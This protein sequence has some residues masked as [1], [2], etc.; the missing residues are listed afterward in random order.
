MPGAPAAGRPGGWAT[1][2]SVPV[3]SRGGRHLNALSVRG[4]PMEC[5]CVAA[6]FGSPFLGLLPS[7]PISST[8]LSTLL[9]VPGSPRVST[10]RGS[11]PPALVPAVWQRSRASGPMSSCWCPSF[12][13]V[14]LVARD[15]P[16]RQALAAAGAVAL[17]AF[18]WL[19]AMAVGLFYLP[20][21]AAFAVGAAP[22]PRQGPAA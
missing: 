17:G 21:V 2:R 15:R 3:A 4:R 9:R 19:G 20:A 14:P 10:A 13:P 16:V 8:G 7:A 22:W 18:A 5:L 1:L 12:S 11:R 6:P